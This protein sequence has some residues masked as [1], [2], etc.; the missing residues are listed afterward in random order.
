M[1]VWLQHGLFS[2]SCLNSI[3]LLFIC[4]CTIFMRG[5]HSLLEC[6]CH[7]VLDCKTFRTWVIKVLSSLASTTKKTT[8]RSFTLVTRSTSCSLA[9]E[10]SS[11]HLVPLHAHLV[12]PPTSDLSLHLLSPA[13]LN[14]GL[15]PTQRNTHLLSHETK[16]ERAVKIN[17]AEKERERVHHVYLCARER[18]EKK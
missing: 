16:K 14:P 13:S 12:N 11:A 18:T 9:C 8:C 6:K 2:S 1:R 5:P 3:D 7:L 15:P 10:L 4:Y 17:G